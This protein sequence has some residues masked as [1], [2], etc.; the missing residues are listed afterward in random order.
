MHGLLHD[1]RYALRQLRKSPRFT[2][3]AVITL[4]LGVGA[5]T[6]IFS[7]VNAVLLRPL[8]YPAADRLVMVWEQ[9]P[10]RGW[11]ENI[12][13]GANF[14]DW[15]KQ[16]RV[17]TDIAAFESNS[18]SLNGENNTEEVAGERVTANLFSVLGVQPLRGRLFLP[19]EETQDRAAVI[20]SYGL[21]Q[22]RY[23]GDP[24]LIGRHI[25]LNGKGYPVVGILPPS[26]SDDYSAS[27]APHS[28]LWI[29]GIEPFPEGREMH[30]YHALARLRTGITLAQAQANMDAIARQ[31]EQQYPESKGWGVALVKL[32]DQAVE[33]ARP[34]LLVL[35]GAVG[36]VLL[37][38]C[39][40]VA[41]LLLVR[42][43]GRQRETAVRSALGATRPRIV[44]QF[45][46]ESTLLSL[47]GATA[48]L[49][50]APL[51]SRILERLSPPDAPQFEGGGIN[52]PVLLFA[53]TL[54]LATGIVFGLA[55]ALG[56]AKV[57]VNETLKDTGRGLGSSGKN[58]RL[59]DTLVVCE[60]GLA[61]ALLVGA[62]LMIKALSHLRRVDI[63]FNPDRLLTL[64]VSLAGSHH[65][66]PRRQ[67][68]FF[69]G[70][71]PWIESLPGV[72]SATISR[73]IPMRGWAGWNF[74]TADNPHPAAGE[75]PDANY[76]V[77]APHYFRTMQIPVLAGRAFNDSDI[78]S[79]EP[80][81]LVS[82]SLA[83]KYWPGQ[84]PIGK[85][86]KIS[87][88]AN[89]NTQAW[90][91]VVGVAGNVRSEGQYAPFVPE[92]YVPYTQYP[93]ILSP[94]NIL[95]RTAADPLAVVPAIR[96]EITARDKDVPVSEIA[97]MQEVVAGPMQQGRSVMLLLG[98][99]ASLALILS[100][101]GIYGVISYS[102]TQRT[103]EIGLRIA[104]G[105]G[106]GDVSALVLRH[107]AMLTSIGLGAGL[108]SI[109]ATSR[110]FSS[111]SFETRWLLLFDVKPFD[112]LILAGVSAALASVAL[113]A[114][115]IPARRAAK[116]DPMMALRYE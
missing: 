10:H 6:A 76:V 99:F 62:G 21:W 115:Y 77:V 1:L 60:F 63:G 2:A 33:Y 22:Q 47:M 17:F 19:E 80:V 38:A 87:S 88:D 64:R 104:L 92:I 83:R 48:G 54:A 91:S 89:D 65:Q 86:L 44:R 18:F 43:T 78:A 32:H 67:A 74:V 29:S 73:G 85:R 25:T 5:N 105:A 12:V 24:A 37:I 93:W 41:N 112:P 30:D 8:P 58:R 28:L 97:A 82:D 56:A 23:G 34:A 114:S 16:N 3:V 102:V 113:L 42:A 11:F 72:Q 36:L 70:L 14:R 79:A 35:L 84:D 55:P 100:A 50:F 111:L 98:G 27:F 81:V 4:A 7:V 66:D 52:G 51:A 107:G 15:Q 116:V 68:E 110:L 45:L 108:L 90:R 49:L 57:N 53:V 69:R 96:R 13:S 61:L 59:R 26:F 106:H 94:R 101:V 103:H 75:T 9:N 39:A 31:F 40:N 20:L 46:A 109:F 71:L 95:V